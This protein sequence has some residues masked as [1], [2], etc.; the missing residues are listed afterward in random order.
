MNV[1]IIVG[2]RP[3]FIKAAPIL[4]QIKKSKVIENI[5]IHTGQ[6]YDENMSKVFFDEMDI[7]EPDFNLNIG[8]GSHGYQTGNM[9]IEIEKCLIETNPDM[10]VVFGDTNSTIAGA[11][12]AVKLHIKVAHIE[13]G[14]RSFNRKMP[15]EINRIATDHI[16]DLLFAPTNLAVENLI[17]EGIEKEKIFNYG[18][19]MYDAA[20][21]FLEKARSNSNILRKLNLTDFVLV[22]I[23]RAENTDNKFRLGNIFTALNEINKQIQVICPLHPRTKRLLKEF[24]IKPGFKVIDPVGYLDMIMLI[25]ES[26]MV[27]TDSG[28]LQ[29]EA[30]FFNKYCITLREETEWKELVEKDYNF[31]CG[32]D[33]EKIRG[34]FSEIMKKDPV[35]FT[36]RFY[37]EGN[38]S[39]YIVNQIRQTFIQ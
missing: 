30:F 19:V 22:S 13:S 37:G 10:V 8:S 25:N 18:D 5:L 29:K 6:H 3:Q 11:L 4:M 1:A 38:S 35:K 2:A 31:I 33:I 21:H 39:E 28:G 34:A 14:L 12:A 16:S 20:L 7:P 27:L 17:M 26:Q 24:D 32:S 23:H 36:D 9:L 15:E